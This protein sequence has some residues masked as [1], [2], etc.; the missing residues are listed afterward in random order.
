MTHG[1]DADHPHDEPHAFDGAYWEAHWVDAAPGGGAP[2]NPHLAEL[3][4]LAPGTALEAGCGEGGEAIE[5]A[6]RGWR[7]TAV[8][9]SPE[10]LARARR[11]PG[12][13]AVDWREADLGTWA[14]AEPVDLVTTFYAHP[15]MPQLDFY[16][17]IARWVAPGGT[18]LVVGHQHDHGHPEHASASAEAV[19]A[20][21]PGDDWTIASAFERPRIAVAPGGGRIELHDVVVRAVRASHPTLRE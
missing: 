9:V 14:P 11:R 19:L 8:D 13:D 5:L 4:G 7:V 10:A 1:H 17:R 2:A 18:L 21:L 3:D 20:R 12:A 6:A 15:A 16:A